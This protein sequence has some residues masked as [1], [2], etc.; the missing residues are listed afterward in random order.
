MANVRETLQ[1]LDDAQAMAAFGQ[2]EAKVASF[3]AYEAK[4][5]ELTG[6]DSKNMPAMALAE[7]ELNPRHMEILQAMGEMLTS[8]EEA[9]AELI[10]ELKAL[11]PQIETV[12]F[13]EPRVT[14]DLAPVE[15]LTARLEVMTALQALRTSWGQVINGMRGFLAFRDNA[16]RENTA[17]YLEQNQ[18]ALDRL[19]AA[20]EQDGLTFEQTDAL[21]RLVASRNAYLDAL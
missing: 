5:L 15:N 9:Q 18:L 21:E 19:L 8:E 4:I 13:G 2:L 1:V 20:A 17:L 14:L 16:L 11:E 6:S 7:D 3:A 10:D 12:S